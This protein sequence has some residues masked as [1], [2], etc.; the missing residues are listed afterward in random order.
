MLRL[1]CLILLLPSACSSDETISAFV[2]PA[3]VFRLHEIDGAAFDAKATVQFPKPGQITGQA[4]C[5]S[6]HGVQSLP[7]PWF[8]ADPIA[9]TKRGCPDLPA[10]ARFFAALG[11]MTLAEVSGDTLIL[12]NDAGRQ[13]LFRAAP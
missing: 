1:A 7:Y 11:D 13:M 10:E 4:P 6:F 12:S 2:D 9:A 5:N 3:T 8:G